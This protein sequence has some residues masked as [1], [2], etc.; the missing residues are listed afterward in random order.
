MENDMLDFGHLVEGTVEKDPMTGKL[1]IRVDNGDGIG[2]TFD[3]QE[4]LAAYVGQEVRLTLA[5]FDTLDRL[6]ALVNDG[7]NVM[8]G[9]G[10]V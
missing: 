1:V 5:T 6:A 8:V 10:P 3:P 9:R 4:A 7:K 2:Y